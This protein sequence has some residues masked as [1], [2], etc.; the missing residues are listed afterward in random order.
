MGIFGRFYQKYAIAVRHVDEKE[1]FS[2]KRGFRQRINR[3]SAKR[4][5]KLVCRNFILK[6]WF[7]RDRDRLFQA[8][9]HNGYT[10]RYCLYIGRMY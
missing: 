10:R 6:R 5:D 1:H 8:V 9:R 3:L 7:A 2:I 4:Y